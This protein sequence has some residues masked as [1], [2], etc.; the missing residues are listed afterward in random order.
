MVGYP[1]YWTQYLGYPTVWTA[2]GKTF[3]NL[4][5]HLTKYLLAFLAPNYLSNSQ[6]YEFMKFGSPEVSKIGQKR[7]ML[8]N[9]P[10]SAAREKIFLP[11]AVY[12]ILYHHPKF[13]EIIS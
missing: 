6:S 7:S 2:G 8:R 9:P 3:L 10:K 5:E 12:T 13:H 4:L 11:P 1:K